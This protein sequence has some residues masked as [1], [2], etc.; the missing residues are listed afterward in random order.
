PPSLSSLRA[1]MGHGRGP[2]LLAALKLSDGLLLGPLLFT[3]PLFKSNVRLVVI[4]ALLLGSLERLLL[5]AL[6]GGHCGGMSSLWLERS[7]A[8]N[9]DERKKTTRE[10]AHPHAHIFIYIYICSLSVLQKQTRSEIIQLQN[11]HLGR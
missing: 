11:V 2:L 1:S 4:Q 7:L 5:A 3:H 8:Q 10:I 6:T 9:K